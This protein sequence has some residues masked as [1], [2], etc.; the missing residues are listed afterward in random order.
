VALVAGAS[1][2]LV[3][4]PARAAGDEWHAGGRAGIVDLSGSGV[5]PALGLHGAYGLNDVFDA[6]VEM[7][8]SRHVGKNGTDT[9]SACGGIAYKIDVFEW[10]P[11]VALLAGY[12]DYAG[13]AGPHG[14]HGSAFGAQ[15]QL[16]LD[17]LPMRELAFGAEARLHT[18][19]TDGF[20]ASFFSVTLGAE[21]RWG[22]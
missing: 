15:A 21:Y 19:F 10:I 22:W 8:G 14:E 17:Y 5:E 7:L 13:R 12:Y 6:T 2:A 9:L 4:L 1:T 18:S 3:P 20:N 11:Y 16:G